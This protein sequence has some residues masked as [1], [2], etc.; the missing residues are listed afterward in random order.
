MAYNKNILKK[1]KDHKSRSFSSFF[2]KLK[3]AQTG[4]MRFVVIKEVSIRKKSWEC[5]EQGD[6]IPL[7]IT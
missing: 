2:F 5:L 7:L 6:N 3:A 1:S 4:S